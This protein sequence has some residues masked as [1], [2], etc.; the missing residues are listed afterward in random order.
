MTGDPTQT[1]PT[2]ALGADHAGVE[3]KATLRAV[4]E[5]EG[6]PVLDLGTN[7]TESV[8]YPDFGTAVAQAVVGGRARFGVL[9]CGTGI[10][11]SI[12]ANRIPGVRCANVH[13]STGAR[14]T[15]AHN[16]ANVIAFG[17]RLTGP[18]VALDA[19][20]A[21][22][23][24]PFEGGRHERRVRKLSPDWERTP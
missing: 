11:I 10:G 3:L 8:D 23:S 2:I 24:T 19:L 6:Y 12:S 18:E 14:L 21:F 7:G 1:R 20:R 5:G 13:D 4:L 17:A 9:V 22:L 15:R 16:D